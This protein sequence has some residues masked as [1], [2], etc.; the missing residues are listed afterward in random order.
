MMST[1][2]QVLGEDYE[3]S[4]A[5]RDLLHSCGRA[6]STIEAERTR[7]NDGRAVARLVEEAKGDDS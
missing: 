3:R 1:A 5:R 2:K 6:T 7:R 4:I